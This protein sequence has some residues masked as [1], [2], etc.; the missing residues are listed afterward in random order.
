MADLA[1]A[2]VK[3]DAGVAGSAITA[4]TARGIMV[5]VMAQAEVVSQFMHKDAGRLKSW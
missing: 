3:V 5:A 2:F 4:S 1:F